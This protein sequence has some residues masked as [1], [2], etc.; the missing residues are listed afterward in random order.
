M[1]FE[2]RDTNVY[3][4]SL[5]YNKIIKQ[6]LKENK[7]Q[8]SLAD[9]FIR[10]ANSITLNIAEGYGRFHKADKRHFYVT[11]R[12]SVYECIACADLIYDGKIPNYIIATS[13]RLAKMLSGLINKFKD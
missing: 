3:K 12:A 8:R 11:A 4:L 5:D 10:A 2:F 7:I 1:S 6:I 13:E 9:Q